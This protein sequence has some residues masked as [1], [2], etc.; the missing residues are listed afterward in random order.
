MLPV[1]QEAHLAIYIN[2][3]SALAEA[4]TIDSQSDSHS[5]RSGSNLQH[6]L[7]HA[8]RAISAGL[9]DA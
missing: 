1:S 3:I 4:G 2:A 7:H 8:R 5:I 6:T 9:D